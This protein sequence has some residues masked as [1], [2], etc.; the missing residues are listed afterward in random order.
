MT[1]RDD[2]DSGG[3]PSAEDRA[4]IPRIE[5]AQRDRLA[6]TGLLATGAAQA[7]NDPLGRVLHNLQS[8]RQDLPKLIGAVRLG[9]VETLGRLDD[10]AARALARSIDELL[11][12][13]LLNDTE[14]QLADAL[15]G[16]QRLAELVHGL[17]ILARVEEA[18]RGPVDLAKVIDTA[19]DFAHPEIACRARLLRE[20]GRTP[21]IMGC[22]GQLVHVFMN[23][24]VHAARRTD[25]DE[26][27]KKAVTVR[28]W[29]KGDELC[30]AVRHTGK[31]SPAPTSQNDA[32][33]GSL[34]GLTISRHIVEAHGGQ[35][36]VDREPGAA[37]GLI[38][39]LPTVGHELRQR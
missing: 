20:Y 5:Q 13:Q 39:R 32:G 8:L 26:M 3:P 18:K 10:E 9:Y 28:T 19:A 12:P 7:I 16:A 34:L 11:R 17:E 15:S 23:L 29:T 36:V 4:G 27:K 22:D 1:S 30:A 38:V 31:G 25:S 2:A 21:T 6:C 24:L 33:I 35:L 37:A 14:A